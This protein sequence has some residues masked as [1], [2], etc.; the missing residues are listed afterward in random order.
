MSSEDFGRLRKTSDFF[1][2][3]RKWSCRLQ[4]FQHSQDKN[5]TLI[6]QKKLAGIYSRWVPLIGCTISCYTLFGLI[7]NN[8]YRLQYSAFSPQLPCGFCAT[9]PWSTFP[10]T[11]VTGYAFP[12]KSPI[13]AFFPT[14][15][16]ADYSLYTPHRSVATVYLISCYRSISWSF[17]QF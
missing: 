8:A 7:E 4:K 12:Y 6:S 11:L 10:T 13:L 3:L 15:T 5:L 16:P 1:G 9:F 14:P 2:N 17:S